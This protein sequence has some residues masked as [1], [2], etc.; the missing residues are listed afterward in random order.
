MRRRHAGIT[1]D[2]ESPLPVG[3]AIVASLVLAVAVLVVTSQ[4]VP[5]AVVG[6]ALLFGFFDLLEVVHQLGVARSNLAAIAIVLL[7]V[8]LAT[9][10]LALR[11]LLIRRAVLAAR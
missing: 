10:V 8:H 5:L 11:L 2:L 6:F 7:A 1:A 9:V 3:A 4:L